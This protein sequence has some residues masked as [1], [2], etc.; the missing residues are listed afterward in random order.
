M[1]TAHGAN[2][3]FGVAVTSGTDTVVV[4]GASDVA[5]GPAVYAGTALVAGTADVAFGP[6]VVAGTAM[7]VGTAK[8]A[9][10]PAVLA[11][12]AVVAGTAKVAFGTA[13]LAGTANVLFGRWA[14][15]IVGMANPAFGFAATKVKQPAGRVATARA[16]GA[17]HVGTTPLPPAESPSH[18]LPASNRLACSASS[19]IA[20]DWCMPK[21]GGFT[22]L[23]AIG[24][25]TG[26]EFAVPGSWLAVFGGGLVHTLAP[27]MS[28]LQGGKGAVKERALAFFFD[29]ALQMLPPACIHFAVEAF[30]SHFPYSKS[31]PSRTDC[32]EKG[33]QA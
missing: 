32:K 33:L 18:V 23:A 20:S 16:G 29:Q 8:V 3:A 10:G 31:P 6:A 28:S 30:Q 17:V 14:G 22:G 27:L 2:A 15:A 25:A 19:R 13:V 12:T 1:P 24:G 26:R 9:F 5:F 11:G 21:V 4:A 7:L